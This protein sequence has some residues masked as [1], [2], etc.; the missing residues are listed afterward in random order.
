MI[1]ALRSGIV[2]GQIDIVE[3]NG[4]TT[5]FGL[6]TTESKGQSRHGQIVVHDDTFW[7]RVFTWYDIGCTCSFHLWRR[8]PV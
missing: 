1:A 5:S 4:T 8:T 3:Q 2:N 6:S 7:V